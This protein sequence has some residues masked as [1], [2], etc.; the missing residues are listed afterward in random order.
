M[1]T[2]AGKR[3]VYAA[4]TNICINQDKSKLWSG[5]THDHCDQV[6]EGIKKSGNDKKKKGKK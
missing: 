3:R 5:W 6:V 4:N 1:L 2:L